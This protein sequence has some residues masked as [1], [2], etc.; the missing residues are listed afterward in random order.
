M[1]IIV[2]LILSQK[3]MKDKIINVQFDEQDVAL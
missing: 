2:L 1:Q 3:T